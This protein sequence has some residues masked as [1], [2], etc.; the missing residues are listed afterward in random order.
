[1]EWGRKIKRSIIRCGIPPSSS[2]DFFNSLLALGRWMRAHPA[3]RHFER[4]LQLFEHVAGLMGGE[5]FDY[6]EAG[7]MFGDSIREWS[8]LSAHPETRFYGFD[9][10]TGLPEAWQ[11]GL[12]KFEPGS[13]SNDGQVPR[14]DDARVTFI[15]GLFQDTLPGFL[16]EYKPQKRLIVH[17]DADLYTSTLYWLCTLNG[18]LKTGTILLFD[19]FAVPTHDFRAFLDYTGAFRKPYKVLATA[20]VDFEKIAFELT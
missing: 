10:F 13:F 7:V 2:L 18:L 12:K 8:Q 9:T 5:P 19:D 16:A 15:K 14:V 6:L 20:E 11:T 3:P 4:R 17:C 1:M